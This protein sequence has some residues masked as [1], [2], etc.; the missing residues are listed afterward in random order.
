MGMKTSKREIIEELI[1]RAR[2]FRFCGPGDDP[3]E[4]TAVTLWLFRSSR[5]ATNSLFYFRGIYP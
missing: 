2:K 1:E 3:D 5:I 4:Q